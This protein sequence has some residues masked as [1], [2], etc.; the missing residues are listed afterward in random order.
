[1]SRSEGKW[2]PRFILICEARLQWVMNPL[3]QDY[4]WMKRVTECESKREVQTVL[5]AYNQP[6]FD[7]LIHFQKEQAKCIIAIED[8]LRSRRYVF[9]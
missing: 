2:F 9:L 3:E 8:G 7:D 1:M 4:E 5:Q 6:H